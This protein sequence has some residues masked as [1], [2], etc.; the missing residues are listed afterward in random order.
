MIKLHAQPYDMSVSGFYFKSADEFKTKA[1]DNRNKFG[2]P[3]EEYEIQFIDGDEINCALAKAIGLNQANFSDFLICAEEW[4]EWQK[5]N[6][7]IA[8]G[9]GG[10]DFNVQNDPDHYGVTLYYID[11]LRDLAE[12]FV[13]EGLFGE[14]PEHLSHYIDYEAIAHDLSHDYTMITIAGE[15]IVYRMD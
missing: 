4:E 5:T 2:D 6:T 7:I 14:I 11:S 15:T 8:V 1:R 12:Q 10:H 13:D 9:E 3:V